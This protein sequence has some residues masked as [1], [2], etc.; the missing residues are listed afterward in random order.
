MIDFNEKINR[1]N[2]NSLKWDF[3]SDNEDVLQ[4]WVADMDFRCP[5]RLLEV[6]SERVKQGIFGY[7][8]SSKNFNKILI[9]WILKNYHY[10]AQEA[11]IS[12][13][14]PGI[15]FAVG[16]LL[17]ILTSEGDCVCIHTPNYNGLLGAIEAK[18]RK[19]QALP[20]VQE[21]D[22]WQ[23]DWNAFNCAMAKNPKVL[24]FTSPHNPTGRVW[25]TQEMKKICDAC[26]ERGTF[27]ISDEAHCD[28]VFNPNVFHSFMEFAKECDNIA[29]MFSPN[30]TF[31]VGGLMTANVLIANARVKEE[32]E[33]MLETWQVTLD[34]HFG[35]IAKEILYSDEKCRL[36][37]EEVCRYIEGNI[38]FA[39]SY[40]EQNLPLL[41][42][43]KPQGTYMLWIDF[44]AYG[45]CGGELSDFLVKSAKVRLS[46][47]D[48]FGE[49]WGSFMRMNLA[50]QKE[51]VEEAFFRIKEA[52]EQRYK[53]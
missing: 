7:T 39:L 17:D 26:K 51:Q 30:K 42:A 14:P 53:R 3:Y 21:E 49:G 41:K 20:L 47:G 31:N 18:G 37:K 10:K 45:L 5:P 38:D 35:A 15:V 25:S 4:M 24:I 43:R 44:S 1:R 2:T 50:C 28:I 33:R 11:F 48:F 22:G 6:F 16:L 29:V 36:W 9:D 12:S 34:N 8:L 13:C 52:L 23:I 46:G 32:F 27:I 40:I 19:I